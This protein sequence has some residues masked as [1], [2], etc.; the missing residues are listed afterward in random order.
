MFHSL[1]SYVSTATVRLASRTMQPKRSAGGAQRSLS[2]SARARMRV[3][4]HR[5]DLLAALAAA[6]LA[7]V[8]GMWALQLWKASLQVPFSFGTGDELFNLMSIKDVITHGW[9][10]TNPSLGAPFGQEL[11][12]FPAFSGDSLYMVMIKV[13]GIFL[14]NAAVVTNVFF[15]LGFPLIAGIAFAVMR[16]LGVSI[17]AAIVCAVLYAL[18]PYRLDSYEIHIFLS[19][20]FLVPVCCYMVLAVFMGSELFARNRQRSGLRAYLTWRTAAM[21]VLCLLVGS[22]DNYFALFTVALVVPAALLTFLARRRSRPLIGGL[23]AAV[24]ILGA[25]G[26]NGLPT[27]IYQ[28]QHGGDTVVSARLPAEASEWGLSL[29]NLV[30]PVEG[31]RV[32]LLASLA[33]HYYSTASVPESSADSEPNWTNLGLVGT[34]GLLWLAVLLGI[35]CLRTGDRSTAEQHGLHA[36]LGAGLAF[37][38]GTVGG[39]ATLFA[40]IVDPQLHAPNRIVVF[41]AFFALFGAALGLD[42]LCRSIRARR[43]GS[44]TSVAALAVVL[45]IGVLYQTSPE[46]VPNYSSYIEQYN[47]RA[48]FVHAIE[49]QVPANAS[50]FELPYTQFPQNYE[51]LYAYFESN[52]LRWSVGGMLGRPSNWVPALL[53]RPTAQV[54]EGIS[55]VG[56]SGRSEEHT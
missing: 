7:T 22:S 16:R 30:L 51:D 38:I 8:I 15:L 43:Y 19:S 6:V 40:Y 5:A 35:S 27:V 49:A 37:L 26:L 28:A 2:Q 3:N 10:L 53:K 24:L 34:L 50:I 25:V 20:Y 23:V 45:A 44:I 4:G 55:A 56:F 42:R 29:A 31:S 48:R 32:P 11:Y 39:L 47:A 12:D 52:G 36:A 41:I 54:L 1:D 33:H 14:G 9:D 46:M 13:L 17:G 18:L 21:I